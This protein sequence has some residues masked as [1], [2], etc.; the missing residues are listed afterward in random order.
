MTIEKPEGTTFEEDMLFWI[1]VL[2]GVL[3]LCFCLFVVGWA[4]GSAG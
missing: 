2:F 1:A 4:V 3:V